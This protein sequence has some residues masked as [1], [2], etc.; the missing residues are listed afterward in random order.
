LPLHPDRLDTLIQVPGLIDHQ[1]RL[2]VGERAGQIAAQVL[3]HEIGV[4]A[5]AGE[6]MLQSVRRE[7]AAVLGDP[8]AVLALQRRQHTQHQPRHMPQRLLASQPRLDHVQDAG[9]RLT[10][11]IWIYPVGRGHRG[12]SVVRYKHRMLTRWPRRI[13][14]P[15]RTR[16]KLTGHDLRL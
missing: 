7:I 1:D 8:P 2:L 6:Q 12:D 15:H 11:P 9:E 10:P 4:P 14:T 5:G 16:S 13:P 3:T